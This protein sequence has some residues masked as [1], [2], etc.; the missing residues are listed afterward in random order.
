MSEGL[1][2]SSVVGMIMQNPELIAKI[3]ELASSQKHNSQE[4]VSAPEAEPD[5]VKTV[6]EADATDAP[7]NDLTKRERRAGLI[8]AMRPYLSD[9][10]ARTLDTMMTVLEMVD[11][12]RRK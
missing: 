4:E 2:L 5:Y 1:D 11:A 8:S 7:Q 6:K 12:V 10:R 9:D 3:S